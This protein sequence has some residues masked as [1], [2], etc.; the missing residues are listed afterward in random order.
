MKV[1]MNA[2]DEELG[3]IPVTDVHPHWRF[4]KPDTESS[5]VE[6]FTSDTATIAQFLRDPQGDEDDEKVETVDQ[7]IANASFVQGVNVEDVD[8]DFDL[9]ETERKA[10]EVLRSMRRNVHIERP[11][12]DSP[13]SVDEDLENPEN[14]ELL[15]INE[16]RVMKEK[17]RPKGSTN[18]KGLMTR[19]EKKAANSTRRDPSQF[20]H[21]EAS[22]QA[23]RGGGRGRGR[24]R[25]G[26]TPARGGREGT[27]SARG[28]RG[29]TTSARGAT[30]K[31]RGGRKSTDAPPTWQQK[32]QAL[33]DEL[34]AEKAAMEAE[35][36]NIEEEDI[37]IKRSVRAMMPATKHSDETVLG[38]E[39]D[40]TEHE[41]GEHHDPMELSSNS[42]SEYYTNFDGD[43]T[44][45]MNM[46]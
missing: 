25:G 2:V 22:I 14:T 42:D 11:S 31:A 17:G 44:G 10:N 16:P 4:R 21:V 23:A 27:T 30:K 32:L 19:A 7:A 45:D 5:A 38:S 36:R 18:K 34:Q 1:K 37:L 43:I 39:F 28:W 20:E 26:T 6:E 46:A 12:P 29:G 24:G 35:I 3:R 33:K 41:A 9:E 13:D 15:S 40:A 8:E